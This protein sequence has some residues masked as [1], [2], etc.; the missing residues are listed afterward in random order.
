MAYIQ[1]TIKNN[2]HHGVMT[3]E[4]AQVSNDLGGANNIVVYKKSTSLNTSGFQNEDNTDWFM[5]VKEDISNRSNIDFA[6][7]DFMVKSGVKYDY[8]IDLRIGESIIDMVDL[9][10]IC[11]FNGISIFY[12]KS[13]TVVSEETGLESEY[14]ALSVYSTE[15]GSKSHAMKFDIKKNMD[16][17]YVKTLKGKYP[18]RINNS[19]QNYYSG[20]CTGLFLPIERCSNSTSDVFDLFEDHGIPTTDGANAYKE[21]MMEFLCNGTEKVLR[22][23]SG[24]AFIV[25]IDGTPSEDWS[26]YDG[27]STIT[28]SWTQIGKFNVMDIDPE[29]NPGFMFRGKFVG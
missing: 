13:I 12:Q 28:F 29:N 3:I 25:S 17:Q 19:D 15:F 27:L 11:R 8:H 4:C 2:E 20:S 22:T 5:V 16:V 26:E 9:S 23:G 14:K 6:Y 7:N 21:S 18:I 10:A 24:K 1:G